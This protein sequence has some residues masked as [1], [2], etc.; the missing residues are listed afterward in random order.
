MTVA[1][2]AATSETVA[3]A[4]E[5]IGAGPASFVNAIL[6]RVGQKDLEQWI[7]EVAPDREQD[8]VGHLAIVHSHPAWVVRALSDALAGHGR[9]RGEIDE[10]LAAQNAAPAV[11]LVMRPGLPDLDEM[12]DHGASAGRLSLFAASWPSG[13]PGGIEPVREGRAAVQDEGSQ[14]AALAL[15]LGADDLVR[16]E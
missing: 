1:P 10:L 4:R 15:G 8:P 16:A 5:M 14:L 12:I 11:S 6:R 2:H 13:D 9:D 3:L 7:D